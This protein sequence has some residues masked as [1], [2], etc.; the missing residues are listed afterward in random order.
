MDKCI[1][2]EH[3]LLHGPMVAKRFEE[4]YFIDV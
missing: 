1:F 3:I 4:K 2:L